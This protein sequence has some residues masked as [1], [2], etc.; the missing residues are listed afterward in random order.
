[1]TRTPGEHSKSLGRRATRRIP[2][3]VN[4][5][6]RLA[7]ADYFFSR[8]Q[9]ARIWD[10]DGNEYIDY[11]LGQGPLLLGHAHPAVNGAVA[12]ACSDGMLFGAQ[13]P[14]EVLAAER[15]CEVVGWADQVRLGMT[16]TEVVQAVL[17]LAR[18][19][20]GR[21]LVVRATGHYHGWL[22]NILVDLSATTAVPASG[23]QVASALDGL[24]MAPWNDVDALEEIFDRCGNDIAALIM[25]PMMLNSGSTEPHTDYLSR[26]REMCDDRGVVLIFDEVITGFRLALGGA[27]EYYGVIPDL[28]TYGKAMAGGWPVAAF[29]GR[30]EIMS[31]LGDGAVNHSGTFNGS[32]MAAAAVV[33][34]LSL[35]QADPPYERIA[36]FGRSLQEGLVDIGARLSVPVH[37]GGVP[38]AFTFFV[39]GLAPLILHRALASA[40]VWTTGRGLWFVSDAHGEAELQET[41]ERV[42]SALA[43]TL[44]RARVDLAV[45]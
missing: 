34:T 45:G 28:A 18:A 32:V 1:V 16:G 36:G 31:L 2:G 19:H 26:V 8:G 11:A 35:L 25:E 33:A 20:T 10:V 7:V 17:R 22:D 41:L 39:P 38:A 29:A 12:L 4:S 37:V 13:H 23:G 9:G 15:F 6:V 30:A 3:G 42:E 44:G 14:L 5:N 43:E 24:V 40:G 21:S 27:A